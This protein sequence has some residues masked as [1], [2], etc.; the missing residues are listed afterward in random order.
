MI[1]L[2]LLL[3]LL[4]AVALCCTTSNCFV[5]PISCVAT[6]AAL[7]VCVMG[8]ERVQQRSPGGV[9]NTLHLIVFDFN[10]FV[11][12]VHQKKKPTGG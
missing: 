11:C 10:D 1:L 3:Q 5:S 6:A 12:V 4:P 7:I 9:D 8:C 2:L